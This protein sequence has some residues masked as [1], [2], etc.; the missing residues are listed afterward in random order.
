MGR[1]DAHYFREVPQ[2]GVA[3]FLHFG[4]DDRDV[5]VIDDLIA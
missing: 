1:G 2:L 5:A 3:Y 4:A